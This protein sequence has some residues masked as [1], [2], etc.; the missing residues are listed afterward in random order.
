[1]G[2]SDDNPGSGPVFVT[3]IGAE[4]VQVD[5][6]LEDPIS[7]CTADDY[8][9][10]GTG[11]VNACV[12]TGAG[13]GSWGNLTIEFNNTAANQDACQGAHVVIGYTTS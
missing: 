1:L 10:A 12:P 8:R 13:R 2:G 3:A 5:D 9:I 7:G 11:T 6:A 4:V